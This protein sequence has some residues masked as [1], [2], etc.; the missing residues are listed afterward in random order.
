MAWSKGVM[1]TKNSFKK[2][3]GYQILIAKMSQKIMHWDIQN[4]SSLSCFNDQMLSNSS[5]IS[6]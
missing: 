2:L 6:C 1:G 4:P 5:H 3:V